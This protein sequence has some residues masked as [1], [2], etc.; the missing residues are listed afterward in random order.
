[1]QKQSKLHLN[2]F[3]YIILISINCLKDIREN[4]SSKLCLSTQYAPPTQINMPF[5]EGKA[6]YYDNSSPGDK[7]FCMWDGGIYY[8]E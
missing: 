3:K 2:T 6:I 5:Q 7:L 4:I 8:L 1:M